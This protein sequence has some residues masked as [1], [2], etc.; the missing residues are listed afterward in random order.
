MVDDAVAIASVE[1]KTADWPKSLSEVGLREILR[2]WSGPGE[3]WAALAAAPDRSYTR[4]WT[5]SEIESR[6]HRVLLQEC[7]PSLR[8]WPLKT[9]GWLE[10]LPAVSVSDRFNS[11]YVEAGVSWTHTIHRYG[12][13]PGSFLGRRRTRAVDSLLVTT[14]KW[15]L[16]RLASIHESAKFLVPTPAEAVARQLDAA[17]ALLDA[18]PIVRAEAI[19]PTAVDTRSLRAEGTPWSCVADTCDRLRRAEASLLELSRCTIWPQP[20][21]RGRLFHLAVLGVLLRSLRH[22]DRVVTS[23]RPLGAPSAGP[24][25]SFEDLNGQEAHLWFEA[26][27]AWNY[28]GL[29]SPYAEAAAGVEGAGNPIGAD[30]MLLVPSRGILLVECKYSLNAQIVARDGYEQAVAYAAEAATKFTGKVLSI[31]VG[32]DEVIKSSHRTMLSVGTI[33]IVPTSEVD[34]IVREFLTGQQSG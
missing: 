3:L 7:E 23:R 21:L 10:R 24:A 31:V 27:G 29:A 26:A 19:R 28:Y 6:A 17:L 1:G 4:T 9:E 12:W 25:Y 34:T 15:V 8:H 30:L 16:E 14:M 20:Q 2:Q 11:P 33:A 22:L 18:E 13:P 5:R 32:P